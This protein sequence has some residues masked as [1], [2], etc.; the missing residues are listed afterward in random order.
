MWFSINASGYFKS[1]G[2]LIGDQLTKD[3]SGRG[4]IRVGEETIR[5]SYR[6]KKN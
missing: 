4:L 5:A 2:T 6:S 1:L 3:L